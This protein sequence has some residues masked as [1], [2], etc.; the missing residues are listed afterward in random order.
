MV[1]PPGASYP[2]RPGHEIAGVVTEVSP[3][4]DD[5]SEIVV[6]ATVALHPV[7]P[8]RTCARCLAG[9]ENRCANSR[10]L[11]IHE[12]GGMADEL[13]WPM[14]RLVRVDGVDP[15]EAALLADAVATAYH[16][17]DTA[18]PPP[19]STVIVIGAGGVGTHLLQLAAIRDPSLRLLAIVRSETTAAR[20]AALGFDVMVGLSEAVGHARK[21]LGGVQ[22]VVD[23]SGAEEAMA[24]GVRMLARGGRFVAGS[25]V[26]TP[27]QLGMSTAALVTRELQVVGSFASTISDLR[28]VAGYLRD[29]LLD[30]SGS[31]S[32]TTTLDDAAAAFDTVSHHPPGL[33]RLVIRP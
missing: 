10:V 21:T 26:D 4:S 20:V 14:D 31:V 2:V 19:D 16:A 17:L 33:V 29:G 1:L 3:K 8:C 27:A 5:S 28:A 23:F 18:A 9:Q 15:A 12:A 11:G 32:H 24:A 7:N 25:V 6:G 30:L 13:T 22:T